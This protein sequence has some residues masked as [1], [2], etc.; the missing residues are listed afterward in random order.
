MSSEH[1]IL[2][3]VNPIFLKCEKLTETNGMAAS[4]HGFHT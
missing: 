2:Y 3:Q 4:R 1:G